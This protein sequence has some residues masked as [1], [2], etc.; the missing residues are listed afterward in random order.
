MARKK[1]SSK[2]TKHS[3]STKHVSKTSLSL[4][5]AESQKN[6]E[7]ETEIV[8]DISSL[9]RMPTDELINDNM[10]INARR[11]SKSQAVESVKALTSKLLKS[12]GNSIGGN[13]S[14]PSITMN[15]KKH[16]DKLVE[17]LNKTSVISS[18]KEFK[19]LNSSPKKLNEQVFST[20]LSKSANVSKQHRKL[21]TFSGM[22]SYQKVKNTN[23]RHSFSSVKKPNVASKKTLSKQISAK[24]IKG[25]LRTANKILWFPK[26]AILAVRTDKDDDFFLCRTRI[27]VYNYTRHVKINWFVKKPKKCKI[28]NSYKMS[29]RDVIDPASIIM[30]VNIK[31]LTRVTYQLPN[32]QLE[33]IKKLLQVALEVESGKKTVDELDDDVQQVI[34]IDQPSPKKPRLQKTASQRL[35]DKEKKVNKNKVP[36]GERKSRQKIDAQGEPKRKRPTK[37]TTTL[38]LQPRTDIKILYLDPLFETRNPMPYVSKAANSRLVFR[39]IHLKDNKLLTKLLKDGSKIYKLHHKSLDNENTPASAAGLANDKN[40]LLTLLEEFFGKKFKDRCKNNK[41][42]KHFLDKLGTGRLVFQ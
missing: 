42:D 24:L 8:L 33:E 18:D 14:C 40:I 26:D 11:S 1:V 6:K 7:A 20:K 21:Q 16:A 35:R 30:Q 25:N 3:T 29:Y 5:H 22:T 15:G 27:N 12:K 28:P 4:A 19:L 34:I 41:G 9:R 36:K 31:R 38:T 32:D 13:S 10:E 37:K 2:R 17:K 23:K 39:A